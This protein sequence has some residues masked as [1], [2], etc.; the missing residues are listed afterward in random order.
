M[1]VKQGMSLSCVA[2]PC[3]YPKVYT[4]RAQCP[5]GQAYRHDSIKCDRCILNLVRQY[6]ADKI[7]YILAFLCL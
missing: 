7:F 4:T 5:L 6:N 3:R 2:K 1:V